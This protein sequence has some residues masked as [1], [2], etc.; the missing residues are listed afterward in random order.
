MR[1]RVEAVTTVSI[2]F[3]AAVT[4]YFVH[5]TGGSVRGQAWFVA[6]DG[7]PPTPGDYSVETELQAVRGLRA[8]SRMGDGLCGVTPLRVP[9]DYRVRA[10]VEG[11]WCDN[12]DGP[13]HGA[14]LR[15]GEW[16]FVLG[17]TL[18]S[19]EDLAIL[20]GLAVGDEVE[21]DAIGLSLWDAN[22]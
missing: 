13:A 11:A 17:T 7:H 16:S 21:F 2:R 14:Y 4:G 9:G 18:C 22:T 5:F 15:A 8:V 1:V 19:A 10:A 12:S 3:R 20:S 6:W